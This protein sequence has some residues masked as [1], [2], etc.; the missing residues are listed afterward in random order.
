[1]NSQQLLY[2]NLIIGGVFLLYFLFGRTLPKSPTRLNLRNKDTPEDPSLKMASEQFTSK[3]T[4]L[5]SAKPN[6]VILEPENQ[7]YSS[8]NSQSTAPAKDLAIFF[9]YNG[10]DWEAYTVLGVPQGAKLQTVTQAYQN[11]I[12]T[13][14]SSS[15]EFLE[16]AY[17][18]ILNKK[19]RDT[20]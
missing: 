2:I 11:L 14:D 13:Q 9:M 12:Q 1:M 18:S 20:L 8:Q 7:P 17:Q 4:A 10:H 16:Q 5:N 3:T 19:R 6:V 15:Y